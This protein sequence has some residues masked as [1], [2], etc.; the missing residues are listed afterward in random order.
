MDKDSAIE[1]LNDLI[2][3]TIDSIGGY[4]ESAKD[5]DDARLKSI[6]EQNAAERQK[7]VDELGN[8]VRRLGGDPASEGSLMGK[9]HHAW[10][11]LKSAIVDRD[12]KAIVNTVES[13]EDY[14]KA[15]YEKA[16]GSDDITGETRQAVERAF[17][18]VKSGHDEVSR[19][20]H[21]LEIQD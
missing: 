7:A 20:K 16:L 11:D 13:A 19:I 21:Q 10:T 15:R 8:E 9:A 6:F 4:R 17:Q 5:V 14:L 12:R 3:V 18:P 2:Q 1:N